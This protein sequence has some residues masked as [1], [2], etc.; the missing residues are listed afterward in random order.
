MQSFPLPTG[1]VEKNFYY[2]QYYSYEIFYSNYIKV[3]LDEPFLSWKRSLLSYMVE[4]Q[5]SFMEA[6]ASTPKNIYRVM[7]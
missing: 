3:L 6:V 4:F 1:G 5:A 7:G 2:T